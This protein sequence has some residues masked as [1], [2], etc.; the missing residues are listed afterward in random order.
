MK[1]AAVSLVSACVALSIATAAAAESPPRWAY[2]ENNPNYKPP[3]DDGHLVRVPNSMA[4]YL[5]PAPGP[6]YRA[7]LAP[8]RPSAT[9]GH[10]SQRP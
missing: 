8:W 1:I 6:I 3:V 10:R 4:L 2:P 5:D 9:A 7:H